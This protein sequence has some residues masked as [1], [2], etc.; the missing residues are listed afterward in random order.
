M[1]IK[2]CGV[3]FGKSI[4]FLDHLLP[5]CSLLDFPILTVTPWDKEIA[6]FNYPEHPIL[7][8]E[9]ENGL[10]DESLASFDTLLYVDPARMAHG[11]YIFREHLCRTDHRSI[12]GLHG[13]S[14]KS[15]ES[16]WFERF[17][18]EQIVL[19]YGDQMIDF[20]KEKGVYDRIPKIIRT[21][22]YRLTFYEENRSFFDARMRPHL[23]KKGK[24]KVVLYAPTWTWKDK[25]SPDYS[26]FFE[27]YSYV[28]DHIPE[29]FSVIVK[30]HP[31][32]WV[33]FPDE[34]REI[35][36]KYQENENI[37]FLEDCPL[38]YPLLD[39]VDIFLGDYSSVSYDFLA[40]DRPLFFFNP[41]VRGLKIFEAGR[42]LQPQDYKRLYQMISEPDTE[43]LSAKRQALYRYAF[44]APKTTS[45]LKKEI[46]EAA[47]AY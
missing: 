21:G 34:I 40:F 2:G 44:G 11:G 28:L 12:C 43:E 39:K 37:V 24:N 1:N 4:S 7:L 47:H 14:E 20:L 29:G 8:A 9:P 19:F 13:N 32:Y 16:Y 41:E 42:I 6:S 15:L 3:L 38:I 30:P 36:E 33:L 22:N 46:L 27:M 31:L 23:P 25:K 10:L 18:N 26:S 5:L 17:A 35:M 45:A